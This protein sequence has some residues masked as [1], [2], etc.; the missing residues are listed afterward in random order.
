MD[1]SL[2]ISASPSSMLETG[3]EYPV[4]AAL[5]DTEKTQVKSEKAM[6]ATEIQR[7][8]YINDADKARNDFMQK[9]MTKASLGIHANDIPFERFRAT[10][11][12]QVQGKYETTFS[13]GK[14]ASYVASYSDAAKYHTVANYLSHAKLLEKIGEEIYDDRPILILED[15]AQ[16]KEHWMTSVDSAFETMPEDWDILKI[17]YWGGKKDEDHVD[18]ANVHRACCYSDPGDHYQGNQAYL[19]KPSAIPKIMKALKKRPV[20]DFDKVMLMAPQG[21]EQDLNTYALGESMTEHAEV[22][23]SGRQMNFREQKMARVLDNIEEMAAQ[24]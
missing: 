1:F 16:L 22:G 14:I 2:L 13:N 12:S 11:A 7:V 8:Y 6:M 4:K 23:K 10:P 18:R 21:K 19:V 24:A 9:Q 20:A 17:G 3:V 5:N 15:D